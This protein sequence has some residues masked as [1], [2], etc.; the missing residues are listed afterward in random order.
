MSK[1]LIT[2]RHLRIHRN[3]LFINIPNITSAVGN[4]LYK[5]T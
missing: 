1:K 3:V 2:I 5:Y 4:S